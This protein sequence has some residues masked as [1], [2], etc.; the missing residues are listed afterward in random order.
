MN[1]FEFEILEEDDIGKR[2]DLFLANSEDLEIS[3]QYIQE[4][5]KD[6]KVLVNDKTT[7]ASYKM[8][9]NDQVVID[10]PPAQE[11]DIAA[12]PIP[13]D[14]VYEDDDLVLVNKPINMVT[15]PATGVYSGTLVNAILYHCKDE[16]SSINGVLR[17]GIVHRLDKDT[18]GLI[19]VAKNDKAHKSLAKQIADRSLERRY[20][21][22]VHS[23]IKA[24]SGTINKKIA[25]HP[26]LRYK[27]AVSQTAGRSATTNWF[28]KQRYKT[29]DNKRYC[30]VECKLETG[31]THQIRVHMAD[32]RHPIVGDPTYGLQK[33]RTSF[34]A[35]RP[36]LHSYKIAFDQPSSG[37]RLSFESKV[38]DDMQHVLEQLK[39]YKCD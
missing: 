2:L 19:V 26:K 9:L 22:L 21:A 34:K 1:R 18:S 25:R 11:I 17:P 38:P 7:K 12:E 29:V 8:Q 23:N 30:L 32:I 37:D 4:L 36:F 27:M 31:R 24:S 35:D 6:S 15:H 16:L 28:V 13:L 10:V 14:I 39:Q 3:R 20:I 5:I 33:E